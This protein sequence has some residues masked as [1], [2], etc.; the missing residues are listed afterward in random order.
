MEPLTIK[1]SADV[2]S[3]IGHTLGFWPQEGLVCITLADNHVEPI[4]RV[5]L[6]KPNTE[7]SYAKMVASYLGHDTS[8]EGVLFA[9]YTSE[10]MNGHQKPQ[11]ATIAAR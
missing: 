7:I 9:V 5:E 4:L 11:V 6:P 2:L 10:P 8:A 1:T 3:F